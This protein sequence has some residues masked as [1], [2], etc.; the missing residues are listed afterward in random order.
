M[1]NKEWGAMVT[2]KYTE[3][4]EKGFL[5]DPENIYNQMLAAYQAGAKYIMIFD[6]SKD[7]DGN[8]TSYAMTDYYYEMMQIFW[9]DIHTKKFA[10]LSGPEAAMVLPANYGWGMRDHGD[11]IWGFWGTDAKTPQI[12]M[13]MGQLIHKYGAQLDIIYDDPN[14]PP[15]KAGYNNIYYWNN[16]ST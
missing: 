8:N 4:T 15:A 13:L 16:S 2:W 10:D 3:H 11:T 1:Q 14:Y 9:N 12:A 7:K 6:Y 5:D